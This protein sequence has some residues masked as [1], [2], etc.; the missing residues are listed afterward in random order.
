MAVLGAFRRV[1]RAREVAFR[2]DALA[3]AKARTRILDEFRKN[4]QLV[5][6]KDI[7]KVGWCVCCVWWGG[8][9]LWL[10]GWRMC[11]CVLVVREMRLKECAWTG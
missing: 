1:M 8:G 9:M 6:D 11:V 10:V 7:Q 5:E 3:L 2:E 4:D